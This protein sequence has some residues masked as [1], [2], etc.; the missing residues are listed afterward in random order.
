M[1]HVQGLRWTA[2][3]GHAMYPARGLQGAWRLIPALI[4][5]LLLGCTMPVE[6]Q[7]APP[8]GPSTSLIEEPA[9]AGAFQ[10]AYL[11]TFAV[12]SV[13][14]PEGV[15]AQ[16]RQIYTRHP[17]IRQAGLV[18][19]NRAIADAR[20]EQELIRA[21]SEVRGFAKLQ[22]AG[23][24]DQ[25]SLVGLRTRYI[26][27]ATA[28]ILDASVPITFESNLLADWAAATGGEMGPALERRV[29][30]NTMARIADNLAGSAPS[31]IAVTRLC[32]YLQRDPEVRAAALERF[33]RIEW[34]VSALAGPIRTVY[35]EFA[36][37]RLKGVPLDGDGPG[38]P[39]SL[40]SLQVDTTCVEFGPWVRRFLGQVRRHWII[41][42]AA[43]SMRGRVSVNFTVHKDGR[44]SDV[45]VA[46]PS[47]VDAFDRASS[48]AIAASNPTSP[49][50]PACPEDQRVMTITFYYNET[51]Q[52]R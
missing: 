46:V 37:E 51:P 3:T 5:M 27:K 42:H 48:D 8:K 11:L 20:T 9:K 15:L 52:K 31:D 17:Q 40:Q 19:A 33:R 25:T 41:P 4:A 7:V 35:P 29:Y 6:A 44:I 2:D 32:R 10:Q 23:L 18:H 39:L 30:D 38:D 43:M 50:P 13:D 34:P 12:L 47:A 14:P 28:L 24:S 16:L 1:L 21:Q 45:T 22:R 49:L 26:A 36:E